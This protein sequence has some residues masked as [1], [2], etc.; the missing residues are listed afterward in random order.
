MRSFSGRWAEAKHLKKTK[1]SR[2]RHKYSQWEVLHSVSVSP[3]FH[4]TETAVYYE[5]ASLVQ[6]PGEKN[7]TVLLFRFLFLFYSVSVLS[8]FSHKKKWQTITK[9]YIVNKWMN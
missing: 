8:H 4:W 5:H 9:S 6:D 2:Q 1:V 3:S 7:K